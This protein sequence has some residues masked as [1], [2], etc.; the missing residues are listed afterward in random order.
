LSATERTRHRR[1]REQGSTDR[2]DLA[3]I[4]AAGVVCHLRVIIGGDAG[5]PGYPNPDPVLPAGIPLPAPIA[6]L[7]GRPA[8]ARDSAR[9]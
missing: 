6:A 9:R 4:L 7:V 3:D 1:R 8:G 5:T 2:R